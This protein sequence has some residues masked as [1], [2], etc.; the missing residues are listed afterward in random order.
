VSGRFGD[1]PVSAVL[2]ALCVAVD[3]RW[4]RVGERIVVTPSR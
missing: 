4:T 2:D 1:E 3:A